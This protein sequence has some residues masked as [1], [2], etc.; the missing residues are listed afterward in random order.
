MLSSL[1][2]KLSWEGG[3]WEGKGTGK[4]GR[5]DQ[6]G[7]KISSVK[8]K[9]KEIYI[10]FIFIYTYT[11]YIGEGQHLEW[12]RLSI[13]SRLNGA[14]REEGWGKGASREEKGSSK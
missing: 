12:S 8:K 11:Y 6:E 2:N 4:G 3:A 1:E 5:V 13:A 9:K 10:H 7:N 14:M